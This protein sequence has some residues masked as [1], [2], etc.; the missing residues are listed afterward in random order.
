M[1]GCGSEKDMESGLMLHLFVEKSMHRIAPP[2]SCTG[3]VLH[4]KVLR[5]LVAHCSNKVYVSDVN[6]MC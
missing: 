4:L 1:I 5:S 6:T 3:I 2:P